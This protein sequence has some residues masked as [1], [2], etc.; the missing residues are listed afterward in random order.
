MRNEAVVALLFVSVLL[1]A[2]EKLGN[3][4]VTFNRDVAP[5]IFQNCTVCHRPGEA[6]PFPLR[7]Y[8]EVKSHAKQIRDVT[9]SHFMPPWLPNPGDFKF[10]DERRLSA[11][12]I[13]IIADWVEK[14]EREGDP[15]DLPP[16]PKF[17]PGWQLGEPDMV[18]TAQKPYTLAASGPDQ[19]W[20]FV[21]RVPIEKTRWVRAVEIR[22]ADKR[23][24]HHANMLV[25]RAQ[26]A[27]H[28]EAE[29]GAGFGGMEI[30][31]ESEAFDPDSHF[32]FWK[33][34]SLPYEGPEGL[35]LRLD[36]GTDLVLNLHMQPSGK[37]ERIQPSVGL[38]F[39]DKPATRHPMLLQIQNDA[40][41]D[42]PPGDDNFVVTSDFTLPV[43]V[44]V[45]AIYPHAH[46]LGTNLLATATLP[47][48][49]K[50]TL[51]HIPHW[52]L[53]WQGV[54]RYAEPV[55]LPKGTT[56]AMRYVY[57][58]SADNVANP[59][60]PPQRVKAGNRAADEMSHLWLQVLPTNG[61]AKDGDPRQLLMEALA[62]RTLENDPNDFEAHY[63]LAS[64]LQAK[65][66]LHE[67]IRHYEL[68]VKLRPEHAVANNALGAALLAAGEPSAAVG[69][70]A[71][72]VQRRP[73]YFDAHYNLALALHVNGD[74]IGT[75]EQLKEAIRIS[76]ADASAHANL[77][78]VLAEMG[79]TGEAQK[80]LLRA[81]EIDP[82]HELAREN[83]T[84]IN[85]TKP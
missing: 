51:I 78:A 69:P 6:G 32:L 24:V 8:Q 76:P 36:P 37:A 74:L 82:Q 49:T 28:M 22:P 68:A 81:L 16:L 5:I 43:D 72:A 73:D 80:E 21:L 84:L 63:N 59:S 65:G 39:T 19:Y 58:N 62:R 83:L 38:Y 56:I 30:S 71:V 17:T 10:A 29:P 40:A 42:I 77:G 75:I 79:R 25:D 70:L 7:T 34:G 12:Q 41:L 13:E 1:P 18:L 53:K 4:G 50:K 26:S 61:V 33:P 14:G 46:Y 45:L 48:G 67:A 44:D 35:A 31:L 23:L 66:S 15:R 2:Q 85:Q 57:D 47:D 9:K 60:N 11:K 64:M 52:D 54:F 27:R 20:N 3:D 55:S